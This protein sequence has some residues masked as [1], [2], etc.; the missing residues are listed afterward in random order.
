MM[1]EVSLTELTSQIMA[2]GYDEPTASRYAVLIG[3]IPVRDDAHRLVV[4]D[5]QGKI[6]A[7]LP[8]LSMFT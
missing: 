3:D 2:Q 8:W 1:T 4:I 5:E 6:L 7:R